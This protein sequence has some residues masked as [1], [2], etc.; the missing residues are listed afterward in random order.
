MQL[1]STLGFRITTRNS[2]NFN[3]LHVYWI[4][5]KIPYVKNKIRFLSFWET[6]NFT[7][8]SP[9]CKY[10]AFYTRQSTRF[11][12]QLLLLASVRQISVYLYTEDSC[13]LNGSSGQVVNSSDR[14]VVSVMLECNKAS[15][16][17][18]DIVHRLHE[19]PIGQACVLPNDEATLQNRGSLYKRDKI[20]VKFVTK[21]DS[22]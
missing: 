1:F 17:L 5:N 15:L 21:F 13:W 14:F 4:L 18:I 8:I 22:R 11:Y 9:C 3:F 2:N 20:E 19:L 10:R 7:V 16:E 6:C 12:L